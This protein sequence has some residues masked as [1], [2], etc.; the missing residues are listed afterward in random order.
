MNIA[1]AKNAWVE[2]DIP[3]QGWSQ[4]LQRLFDVHGEIVITLDGYGKVE[5]TVYTMKHTRTRPV[6]KTESYTLI[7]GRKHG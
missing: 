7:E 5:L 2:G 4:E 6:V 3:K 1:E